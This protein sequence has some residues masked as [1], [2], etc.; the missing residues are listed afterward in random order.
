MALGFGMRNE[1]CGNR[2]GIRPLLF[3]S[4]L[5][6]T[7]VLSMGS[8]LRAEV[9]P[10]LAILP[11][12]IE[13]GEEPGRG[14]VCSICKGVHR[15]GEIVPGSQ[16]T[17]TRELY[18]RMEAL[19][20]FQ[21]LPLEKMEA[22]LSSWDK[23]K[24]EEKPL[25]SSIRLGKELMVDYAMIGIL[26]RFEERIGSSLGVE[27]PASVVFDLHLFRLRDGVKVWDGNMDETQR[28][29]SENLFQVGSFVRRKAKWLTAEELAEVG[30]EEMLKKL[31]GARELEER[32]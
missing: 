11:F 10:G 18:G 15:T 25:S 17:L 13:R 30:M 31:P 1:R 16:H 12:L 8:E 9:K 24:L 19:Q 7:F 28:P 27:R 23:K 14:V 22:A 20:T 32:P 2:K 3:R 21:V 6:L 4:L 29:L 5:L 26:F